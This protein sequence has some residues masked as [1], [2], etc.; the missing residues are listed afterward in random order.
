MRKKILVT[1][2]EPFDNDFNNPSGDWLENLG[3]E[4]FSDR[5]V[6]RVLLPVTFK[7]AFIE[8]QRA[9]EAFNPDIVVQ[10]G[11]AKNRTELTIERIGINWVDARIADN[12]GV[13][14]T[15]QRINEFGVDGIF[16][17]VPIEKAAGITKLKNE[18]LKISTS[19]GEYVCNY[20]LYKSLSYLKEKG[21]LCQLTFIHLPGR[22]S[23]ENIYSAL[24]ELVKKI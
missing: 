9:F 12:D 21:S 24:N 13:V 1:G 11:L 2:F 17:N 6:M 16:T 4:K 5:E 3:R 8:F 19:A 20:L 22:D 14:L 7:G 23:Y 18:N 15:S 10:T